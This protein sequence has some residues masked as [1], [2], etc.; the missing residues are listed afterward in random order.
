MEK[1]IYTFGIRYSSSFGLH[2]SPILNRG[3]EFQN[4]SYN[5]I[6]DIVNSQSDGNG[7]GLHLIKIYTHGKLLNISIGNWHIPSVI[8]MPF[9]WKGYILEMCMIDSQEN[10]E[11]FLTKFDNA[12]FFSKK[13]FNKEIEGIFNKLIE[14]NKNYLNVQHY[15]I[16]N[17]IEYYLKNTEARTNIGLTSIFSI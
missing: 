15:Q 3:T 17:D 2:V 11:R 16:L 8:R 5:Y 9:D 1:I 12:T 13:G 6:A 7:N 4:D 14:F 10:C